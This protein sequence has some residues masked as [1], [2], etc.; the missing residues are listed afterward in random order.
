MQ[1]IYVYNDICAYI[2]RS[3]LFLMFV[4][5]GE[6]DDQR[7]V[8]VQYDLWYWKERKSFS[9][10]EYPYLLDAGSK[11]RYLEYENMYRQQ[12]AR[13]NQLFRF[14]IERGFMSDRE[15]LLETMDLVLRVR[16]DHLI[17]DT[18][19]ILQL[20]SPSELKRRL[21]IIFEGEQ[22]VDQ[23]GLTKE[24]FQLIIKEL[25][26]PKFGMF[27]YNQSTQ[28][29]WFNRDSIDSDA[30]YKLIGVLIGIA[31]YNNTIL[32]F[33][34]PKVMFKKLLGNPIDFDDF[35]DFDPEMARGF[36][37]LLQFNGDVENTFCRNFSVPYSYYGEERSDDLK[38]DGSKI[39]LTND[40]REEYVD[41]YVRYLL[42]E[43]V[44]VQ[45]ESFRRG[46][47]LVCDSELFT[48]FTSGEL[49]LLICGNRQFDFE[50][51]EQTCRYENGFSKQTSLIKHFW[52]IVHKLSE[53]DKRKLLS[54]CTGSDRV[55]IRGLGELQLTIAK[56]GSNDAQLP[57]SHTCFN[58]I[59][60][61]EYSSVEILRERLLTAIQNSEGFGL[62]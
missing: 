34:F 27:I 60:L 20:Y 35:R 8:I 48:K 51:L 28:T 9:Y 18:L 22:G 62:L 43:S 54:F 53:E 40:N 32:D 25:F 1:Y 10:L 14:L 3:L 19:P 52:T 29:Y 36:E 16:R 39:P 56:H 47:Q 26:D 17:E 38:K 30:E 45:F 37:Q 46:F 13:R 12:Q 2:I 44:K 58:H 41:L 49:E 23:G 57:T 15:E 7:V 5:I 50:K 24:F 4:Y 21:R 42:E 61:P 33:R 31:I 6:R 11:A 55:P 59:L